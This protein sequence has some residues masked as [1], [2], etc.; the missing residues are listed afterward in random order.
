M[1]KKSVVCFF[2]PFLFF[3]LPTTAKTNLS[4]GWELW[5]PYQY[6]NQS[7]KLVGLDIDIFNAIATKAQYQ[8]QYTEVPWKRHLKYIKEGKMD[9]AMGASLAPERESYAF[10]TEPYRQEQVKLF[11]KKTK[12]KSFTLQDISELIDTQYRIGI[13]GEYWYGKEFEELKKISE[14]NSKLVEGIDLEHNALELMKGRLDGLLVD[15]IT[16]K[17]FIEKYQLEGEFV[18]TDI[19]VYVGNIY[20]ILSKKSMSKDDLMRFNRAIITLKNDGT[21]D[22]LYREWNLTR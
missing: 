22:N 1:T 15:P 16:M 8:V 19:S 11:I 2:I 7:N 12:E 9:I 14:F 13:E 20:I 18:D 4:V 3:S 17:T 6:H 10:Y 5:Y 21:I